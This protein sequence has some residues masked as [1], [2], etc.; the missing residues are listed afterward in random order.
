MT[1]DSFEVQTWLRY[2]R[3][4]GGT[5]PDFALPLGDRTAPNVGAMVAIPLLDAH[6]TVAFERLVNKPACDSAAECSR[7]RR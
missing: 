2:A 5:L 1:L 6:E 7:A 3:D 4:N